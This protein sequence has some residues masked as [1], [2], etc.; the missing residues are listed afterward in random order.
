M[1]SLGKKKHCSVTLLQASIEFEE[2]DVEGKRKGRGN[3][4]GQRKRWKIYQKTGYYPTG[5]LAHYYD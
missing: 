5:S 4:G 2:V 3:R 1:F